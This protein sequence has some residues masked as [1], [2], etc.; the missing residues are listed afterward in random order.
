MDDAM[1]ADKKEIDRSE[2]PR[3][4]RRGIKALIDGVG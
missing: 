3:D 4:G 2:K 1:T